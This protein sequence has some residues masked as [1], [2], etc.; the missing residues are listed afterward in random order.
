MCIR[1]SIYTDAANPGEIVF[2]DSF[3]GN[4]FVSF[5][6]DQNNEL[7]T[8]ALGSGSIYRIVDLDA[9]SIDENRLSMASVFPNPAKN[10]V[11]LEYP[12]FAKA[13]YLDIYDLNGKLVQSELIQ[14]KTTPF[15]V[16]QLSTGI[17]MA[18]LSNTSQTIK[19]VVQ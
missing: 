6:V 8:A 13:E 19:L 1:D 15:S 9:L 10:E 2:S 7:Y 16:Q 11:V 17:Y 18:R 5:G 14:G 4:A 12:A 3:G